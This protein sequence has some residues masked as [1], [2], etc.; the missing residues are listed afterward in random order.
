MAIFP[1]QYFD[2]ERIK[3]RWGERYTSAA[4]NERFMGLP[5]GVY[6]G[7]DPVVVGDTV[8]LRVSEYGD[9]IV[10]AESSGDVAHPQARVTSTVTLDFTGHTVWPVFAVAETNYSIGMATT[11]DIKTVR[12]EEILS[13]VGGSPAAVDLSTV[14]APLN[15]P[16]RPGTVSIAVILNGGTPATITDDGAGILSGTGLAGLGSINYTTGAMTG[17]TNVLQALSD[18]V[19]TYRWTA[20]GTK[21]ILICKIDKPG[22]TITVD[23]TVPTYRHTPV[24]YLGGYGFGYM[25]EGSVED[26]QAANLTTTEVA[27]AR[28]GV[29]QVLHTVGG[30]PLP[31][32]LATVASPTTLP[33]TPGGVLVEVT[34][35][36]GTPAS[37]TDDGFGGLSG[38]GIIGSGS[39]DYATGAMTGITEVLD[40]LSDV[41][42]SPAFPTLDERLDAELAGGGVHGMAGRLA[43]RGKMVET[44]VWDTG[45]TPDQRYWSGAVDPGWVGTGSSANVS[46]DFKDKVVS[47][48]S[49]EKGVVVDSLHNIV[50][51][52]DRDYKAFIT[53]NTTTGIDT[54]V[55]GRLTYATATLT[56]DGSPGITFA[57]AKVVTGTGTLFLTEVNPGDIIEGPDTNFY[58]VDSVADNFNLLLLENYG[59]IP[60]STITG[61]ERRRYTLT[62][63]TFIGGTESLYSFTS[64]AEFRYWW[65]EL[66]DAEDQTVYADHVDVRRRSSAGTSGVALGRAKVSQEAGTSGFVLP[67]GTLSNFVRT[68]SVVQG[69]GVSLTV[70]EATDQVYIEISA[71][72]TSFPGFGGSS[73]PGPATPDIAGGSYG[74][75]TT[76]ARTDHSHPR[77][78]LYD[79][80]VYSQHEIM[81][82][83]DDDFTIN[84]GLL[85]IDPLLLFTYNC[86][87]G[88]A[89]G[90]ATAGAGCGY[91]FGTT[92]ET[93][94]G[95]QSHGHDIFFELDAHYVGVSHYAAGARGSQDAGGWGWGITNFDGTSIDIDSFGTSGVAFTYGRI[96]FLLLGYS[97]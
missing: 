18:L 7:F 61:A 2:V 68:V 50:D 88:I 67:V 24:A 1:V 80:Q 62:F 95:S 64:A 16:V 60:G 25:P 85:N 12:V 6:R 13:T 9:S 36:G 43:L 17:T 38:D 23:T 15:L 46:D 97:A 70:Y 34:L 82:T 87:A 30:V 42:F 39:I 20:L 52:M 44:K 14:L 48:G 90:S 11:A 41:V 58:T 75:A 59:G 32:N 73:T 57:G 72:G 71:T 56:D 19:L 69:T 4:L 74:T 86:I 21:E 45:L 40:A 31:V 10:S 92:P 55:Y 94:Q 8:E 63:Y 84:T 89:G 65:Q 33:I 78:S 66:Y 35:N 3:I 79:I 96:A 29:G 5:P 26:L 51:L 91:G 81:A 27:N 49:T 37:F 93:E 28:D 77:S 76:A 22:A 47:G 54:N 83:F 53:T